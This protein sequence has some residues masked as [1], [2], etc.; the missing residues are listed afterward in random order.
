MKRL[1]SI[2]TSLTHKRSL[3]QSTDILIQEMKSKEMPTWNSI[4]ILL[5]IIGNLI[6]FNGCVP[7]FAQ[8]VEQYYSDR[9]K[10]G[11]D[12]LEQYYDKKDAISV[13]A[14]VVNNLI[15][16]GYSNFKISVVLN[17][18]EYEIKKLKKFTV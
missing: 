12:A 2:D 13:R 18:S 3:I 17:V 8:T 9:I 11:G 15:K 6:G 4:F 10:E 16:D 1:D 5:K 14:G 7:T